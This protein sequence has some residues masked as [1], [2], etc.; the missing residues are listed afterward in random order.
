MGDCISGRGNRDEEECGLT[1]N[2]CVFSKMRIEGLGLQNK[3]KTIIKPN[4][5]QGPELKL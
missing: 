4:N 1:K 5:S 3:Q 2:F